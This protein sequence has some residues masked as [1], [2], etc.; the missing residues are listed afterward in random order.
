MST[1]PAVIAA[2]YSQCLAG[3]TLVP[4]SGWV[5]LASTT[6]MLHVAIRIVPVLLKDD[7]HLILLANSFS[8]KEGPGVLPSEAY[9]TAL[10]RRPTGLTAATR[11]SFEH[12][13]R[14]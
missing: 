5:H 9:R 1:P 6:V 8:T 2:V 13:I 4:D 7:R 11:S 10:W 14:I 3:Q 12:N